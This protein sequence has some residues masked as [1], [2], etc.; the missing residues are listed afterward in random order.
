MDHISNLL[1]TIRNGQG[2]KLLSVKIKKLNISVQILDLLI[3][4][5]YIRGYKI[6]D[7][8][9][10][11]LLKYN[12]GFGV[13][14]KIERISKPGNKFYIKSFNLWKIQNMQNKTLILSTN[15]GLFSCKD[16]LKFKLGGEVLF[17]IS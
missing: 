12:K 17:K 2:I 16:A 4:N 6:Q 15:K 13:I 9:I 11:V 10:E 3:K 1:T 5:G 7:D 8:F 14:N